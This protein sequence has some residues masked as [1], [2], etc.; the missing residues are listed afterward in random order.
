MFILLDPPYLLGE[1]FSLRMRL[2]RSVFRWR[3][4]QCCWNL[5]NPL[6]SELF[7]AHPNATDDREQLTHANM[8][9]SHLLDELYAD[10]CFEDQLGTHTNNSKKL[11][12]NKKVFLKGDLKVRF[13]GKEL[14]FTFS[15]VLFL[16]N[17]VIYYR[18]QE[19]SP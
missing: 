15:V 9:A 17:S 11:F 10:L 2:R 8:H 4:H 6:L 14:K 13:G 12:P 18:H 1:Y 3:K 5:I 16:A 19:F 7:S